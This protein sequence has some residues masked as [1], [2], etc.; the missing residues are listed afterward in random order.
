SRRPWPHRRTARSRG[1]QCAG[2]RPPFPQDSQMKDAFGIRLVGSLAWMSLASIGA[3]GAALITQIAVGFYLSSSEVGIAALASAIFAI[4]SPMGEQG[5][6]KL[7]VVNR[8]LKY[9]ISPAVKRIAFA[10][11]AGTAIVF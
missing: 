2:G 11:Q 8:G 4:V 6:Q 5:V 7:L 9:D 10:F 1:H 3:K